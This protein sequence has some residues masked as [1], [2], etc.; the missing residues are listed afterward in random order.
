MS[1]LQYS[2]VGPN[3][4]LFAATFE[5]QVPSWRLGGK[6]STSVKLPHVLLA[7]KSFLYFLFKLTH[8]VPVLTVGFDSVV[9]VCLP[10]LS[11]VWSPE[12]FALYTAL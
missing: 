4:I 10:C 3:H 8:F 9:L 12:G 7:K 6:H 11:N 1:R 2:T 5:N